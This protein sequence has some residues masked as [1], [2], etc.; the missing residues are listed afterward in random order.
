[1]DLLVKEL[2]FKEANAKRALAMCDSGSGIDVERAIELLMLESRREAMASATPV[3]LPTPSDIVSPPSTSPPA[4]R[5]GTVRTTRRKSKKD[6]C[7]GGCK[8]PVTGSGSSF[9]SARTSVIKSPSTRK[10]ASAN[11]NAASEEEETGNISPI[12]DIYGGHSDDEIQTHSTILDDDSSEMWRRREGNDTISP[13]VPATVRFNNINRLSAQSR[14]AWKVLGLQQQGQATP[15]EERGNTG[16]TLRG[17]LARMRSKSSSSVVGMEEYAMRVE[18]RKSLRMI[19]EAERR[20]SVGLGVVSVGIG[21]QLKGLGLMG[22]AR[23]ERMS[24]GLGGFKVVD[25]F[26]VKDGG[27][28]SVQ[29]QSDGEGLKR[30][31]S[32][33]LGRRKTGKTVRVASVEGCLPV[34]SCN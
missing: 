31:E 9:A 34:T 5:A 16:G 19:K 15:A 26:E 29:S 23:E 22:S 10:Q 24:G 21:E 33:W 30:R 7:D 25:G 20:S 8:R 17:G 2:G 1:M 32:K 4:S 6:Y 12:T 28:V 3:E 18:R 14:K 27:V 13:L 11:R